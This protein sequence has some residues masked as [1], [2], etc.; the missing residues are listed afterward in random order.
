VVIVSCHEA[1]NEFSFQLTSMLT[2]C[3]FSRHGMFSYP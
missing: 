1:T 2:E 3:V